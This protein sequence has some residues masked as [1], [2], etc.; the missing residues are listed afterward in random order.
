ME[1]FK[2]TKARAASTVLLYKDG[3]VRHANKTSK[4]G[5]KWK[6]QQAVKEAEAYWK[7]QDTKLWSKANAKGKRGLMVQRV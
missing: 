5:R 2:A 6:P 4:C 1:E 7:N 3:Q